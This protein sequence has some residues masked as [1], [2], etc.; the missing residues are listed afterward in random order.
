MHFLRYLKQKWTKTYETVMLAI[1]AN[2]SLSLA[3]A[4]FQSIS[5]NY[6]LFIITFHCSCKYVVLCITVL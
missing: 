2:V 4:I 3:Y 6:Y 1:F 5:F